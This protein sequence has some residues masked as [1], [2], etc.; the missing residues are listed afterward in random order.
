MTADELEEL[1]DVVDRKAPAL[2]RSVAKLTIGEIAI[3]LRQPEPEVPV[4]SASTAA[5]DAAA[6]ARR[7]PTLDPLDDPD[8]YPGGV[9]PSLLNRP[10]AKQARKPHDEHDD[11]DDE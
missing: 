10:G 2:S 4:T 6:A 11:E 9:V 5:V 7:T 3:E 8:A 1:L